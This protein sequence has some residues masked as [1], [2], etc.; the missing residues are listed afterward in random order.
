MDRFCLY[1]SMPVRSILSASFKSHNSCILDGCS[2]KD[3]VIFCKIV[4]LNAIHFSIVALFSS[5]SC[6]KSINI[7]LDTFFFLWYGQM[8]NGEQLQCIIRHCEC[9]QSVPLFLFTSKNKCCVHVC[10][11]YSRLS[12]CLHISINIAFD[13]ALLVWNSHAIHFIAHFPLIFIF[14]GIPFVFQF[15][16]IW[17][18]KGNMREGSF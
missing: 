1:F 18:Q 4:L 5:Q 14:I 6:D 15:K 9:I 7:S 3:S 13:S 2:K 8:S 10:V 11:S 16:K 17:Q 12:V